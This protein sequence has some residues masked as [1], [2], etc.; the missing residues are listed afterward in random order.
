MKIST[1]SQIKK[2]KCNYQ[3]TNLS[4][5]HDRNTVNVAIFSKNILKP[6][7]ISTSVETKY[8]QHARRTGALLKFRQIGLTDKFSINLRRHLDQI[9]LTKF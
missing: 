3:N 6:T 7:F 5:P 9:V 8:T 4:I 1:T 2:L